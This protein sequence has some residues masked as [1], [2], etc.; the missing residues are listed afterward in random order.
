MASWKKVIVSGSTANLAAL[1]VDNLTSGSVVIGG[2]ASSNLT[3]RTINGSGNIVATTGAT[4]LSASGSFSGSFLG[5][6]TS[7]LANANQP[8]VVGYDTATG[9]FSYQGT[10]S[11]TAATASYITASNVY[12][13]FGSNSILS[14]SS[15]A[16]ASKVDVIQ[17]PGA[18]QYSIIFAALSGAGTGSQQLAV[19]GSGFSFEPQSGTL[20]VKNL[21]GTAS[22]AITASY[23]QN[24]DLLD[25]FDSTQFTL[26]SS[27]NAYT[28]SLNSKTSSFATTGSNTFVGNQTISGSLTINDTASIF[29]IVG[30]SFSETYLQSNGGMLLQAGAGGVQIKSNSLAVDNNLTVG[31]SISGSTITGLGNATAFSSSVDSRLNTV[32]S[33]T[34]SFVSTSSFNAYTSSINTYTSSLNS[35]TSSF[36]LNSQTSSMSVASASQAA[37]ASRVSSIADNVTNNVDNRVLTATGGGS[38]NGEANLTFDGSTLTVTGNQTITGDLTVQGTTTTINTDNLLVEDKFILLASG[39]TSPTD[40]GFIIQSGFSGSVAQGLALMYDS[41]TARWGYTSSLAFNA[42]SA[43]P[44]AFASIVLDLDNG[45]TDV[46][47]YQKPGNIK[48]TAGDIF[49]YS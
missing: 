20:N 22:L 35:A 2:G 37:T 31:G 19:T 45:S 46:A 48:V 29:S 21:S 42:T 38:I 34:G 10:G 4:G 28:S 12:G 17:N 13:P 14:A 41:N 16:T 27:F 26:T 39:S 44:D 49:I 15:A 5:N 24:A 3:V 30:N 32:A 23:A 47:A 7:T 43:V 6:L 25:G 9:T 40:G 8:N 1:Q 33:S 18:G 36:V 11:F